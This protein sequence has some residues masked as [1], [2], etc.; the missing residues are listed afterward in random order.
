[1]SLCRWQRQVGD[2]F[3]AVR[4]DL[5]SAGCHQALVMPHSPIGSVIPTAKNVYRG[6]FKAL[7]QVHE[8]F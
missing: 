2:A 4:I 6:V 1:V 8:R 3:E 5:S 7:Y